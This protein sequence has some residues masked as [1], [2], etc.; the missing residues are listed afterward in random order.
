MKV[1]EKWRGILIYF[2]KLGKDKKNRKN[3]YIDNKGTNVKVNVV[4]NGNTVE[5]KNLLTLAEIIFNIYIN[6]IL[7]YS[8]TKVVVNLETNL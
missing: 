8:Y 1:A 2:I 5:V 6:K 7:V 3:Y 4:K